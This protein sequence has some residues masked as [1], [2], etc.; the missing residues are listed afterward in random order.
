MAQ[1]IY[2]KKKPQKHHVLKRKQIFAI[3]QVI[4]QEKEQ[5]ILNFSQIFNNFE[6]QK[7]NTLKTYLK[8]REDIKNSANILAK[9]VITREFCLYVLTLFCHWHKSITEESEAIF[10]LSKKI[11]S[12]TLNNKIHTNYETDLKNTIKTKLSE[13]FHVTIILPNPSIAKAGNSLSNVEHYF[14]ELSFLTLSYRDSNPQLKIFWQGDTQHIDLEE[15]DM[16]WLIRR[17]IRKVNEFDKN[18]NEG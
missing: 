12:S 16:A 17:V 4:S 7:K 9:R 11:A 2:F 18:N 6:K 5:Q 13:Y 14:S 8:E 10:L 1:L 3:N 15:V